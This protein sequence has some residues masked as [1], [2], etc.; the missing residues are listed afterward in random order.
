M[1]LL[2]ILVLVGPTASGKSTLALTLA[3]AFSCEIIAADSRTIY[4]GMDIGTAKPAPD[5][6]PASH[7][8][9]IGALF[10]EKPLMHEGIAHWGFNLRSPNEVFTVSEFQAYADEKIA[11]IHRRGNMPL[12]VGGTGLY[13]GAVIDRPSFADVPPD[14]GL[15]LELAERTNE[16][17][18]E[19]IA[20]RD[21]D[22]AAKIDAHNR[23]RLERALEILRVTGKRLAEV[24]TRG[25]ARYNACMLGLD[26]GQDELDVRIAERVDTMIAAGLVNEVRT[27]RATYGDDAPGMTG[28]G[29]RQICAFLRGEMSLKDAILSLRHDTRQYAKRQ[30]TWFRRDKRIHWITTPSEALVYVDVWMRT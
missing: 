7:H 25:E 27:L 11:E 5:A 21:P 23:R 30:R 20:E 10:A 18:F 12:L 19:E 8:L 26:P 3:R 4:T 6:L 13:V 2:R 15:R 9:D 14:P 28:I 24:Q 16:E 1:P 22:T 17:L 29:Y